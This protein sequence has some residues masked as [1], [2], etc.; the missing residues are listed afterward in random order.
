VRGRRDASA[1][2]HGASTPTG[3]EGERAENDAAI[4]YACLPH[5]RACTGSWGMQSRGAPP[6]EASCC[7]LRIGMETEVQLDEAH[8]CE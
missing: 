7:P 4:R 2:H 1:A 6:G 5:R 3:R 8:L